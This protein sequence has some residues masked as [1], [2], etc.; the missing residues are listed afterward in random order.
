MTRRLARAVLATAVI[1]MVAGCATSEPPAGAVTAHAR[2]APAGFT[3]TI[4]EKGTG[5]Y[6]DVDR[7]RT[8]RVIGE[9]S[10]QGKRAIAYTDGSTTTYI[11]PTGF[12][13]Y[14]RVRDGIPVESFEPPLN[15]SFPLFVGKSWSIDWRYMNHARNTST[16]NLRTRFTVEAYEEVV[17]PAGRFKVF[18]VSSDD[19]AALRTILWWAPEIGL[20]VKGASERLTGHFLGAGRLDWELVS[21]EL[22]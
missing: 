15:W 6:A 12:G 3:W 1:M 21:Y 7:R 10:W 14:A 11:D 9:Q 16:D 22:K 4:S 13:W 19:G 20:T 2:F 18:R 5:S 17:V 8:L